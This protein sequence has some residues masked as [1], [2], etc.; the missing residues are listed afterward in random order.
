MKNQVSALLCVILF[1]FLFGCQNKTSN[2]VSVSHPTLQLYCNWQSDDEYSFTLSS[3]IATDL[4]IEFSLLDDGNIALYSEEF[5]ISKDD[6]EGRTAKNYMFC[7]KKSDIFWDINNITSANIKAYD[8]LDCLFADRTIEIDKYQE[9]LQTNSQPTEPPMT[10]GQKNAL[11]QAHD[12][13]DALSF[14]RKGLLEQLQYEGYEY[15]D[16]LFAVDNCGADWNEQAV[17]MA[18]RYLEFSAFSKQKLIEQ[19]VYKGFTHE[20]AVYGVEQNGY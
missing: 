15:E 14:S 11:R 10:M 19:L 1:L 4:K 8:K 3:T 17:R 7:V 9:S 2:D 16:C 13:L 6:F 12:Y 20:Q 5:S 18:K